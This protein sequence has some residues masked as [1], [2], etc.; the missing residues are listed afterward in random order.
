SLVGTRF[1]SVTDLPPTHTIAYHYGG[2][3][4][5]LVPYVRPDLD[6]DADVDADDCALLRQCANGPAV[7]PVAP[8]CEGADLDA[9]DDVDQGDFGVLQRCYN[10]SNVPA[11]PNCAD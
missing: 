9:D 11:D 6:R 3:S 7:I 4:L 1:A 2:N 10:G 8:G 5:A